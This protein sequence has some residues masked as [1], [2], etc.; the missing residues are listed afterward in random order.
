MIRSLLTRSLFEASVISK[1]FQEESKSPDMPDHG[2]GGPSSVSTSSTQP[3]ETKPGSTNVFVWS[4]RGA[5]SGE[6]QPSRPEPQ[7]WSQ[8]AT[9]SLQNLA[10]EVAE[11]SST[12]SPGTSSGST[13][14]PLMNFLRQQ[15]NQV[16]QVLGNIFDDQGD[17]S[18]P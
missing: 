17:A 15:G 1:D 2:H 10:E 11:S 3:R 14:A 7:Q 6:T 4:R 8:S 5:Q 13:P 18:Q 9:I 16:M 12:T